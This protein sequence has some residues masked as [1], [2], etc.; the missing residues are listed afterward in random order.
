MQIPDV[1]GH[2]LDTEHKVHPTLVSG[3]GWILV[4]VLMYKIDEIERLPLI[5]SYAHYKTIFIETNHYFSNT[6]I[7]IL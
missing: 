7:G 5:C 3:I 4:L 6:H 2:R 1:L